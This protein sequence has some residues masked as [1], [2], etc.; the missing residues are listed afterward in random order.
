M[1]KGDILNRIDHIREALDGV[2]NF[3]ECGRV[4][5]LLRSIDIACDLIEMEL[6]KENEK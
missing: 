6:N 5:T 3:E 2:L 4:E 1:G